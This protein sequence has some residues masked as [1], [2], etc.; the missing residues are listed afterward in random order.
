MR[1]RRRDRLIIGLAVGLCYMSAL[2]WSVA[3]FV[4]SRVLIG[5]ASGMITTSASI[6]LTQLNRSSNVMRAS[7]MTSFAMALGFGLGGLPLADIAALRR[8]SGEPYYQLSGAAAALAE[9][10]GLVPRLSITHEGGLAIAFAVLER[11]EG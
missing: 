4:V 2:A 8:E 1:R 3:S 10:K 6:G 9:E 11:V 7:A 5:I